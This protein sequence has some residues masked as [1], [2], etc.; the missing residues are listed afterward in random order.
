MHFELRQLRHVVAV[1]EQQSFSKAAEILGLTQPALSRSIAA[2]ERTCGTLIF[3][4]LKGR[5][6]PTGVGLGVIA[7]CE[8]ILAQADRLA[9]DVNRR[10]DAL[11]GSISLGFGPLVAGLILPTLL[12][13]LATE[14]PR[15]KIRTYMDTGDVLMDALAR[16][17][18]EIAIVAK[19]LLPV[20]NDLRVETIG[21]YPLAF[22]VRAG[23]PLVGRQD[24]TMA[25]LEQFPIASGGWPRELRHEPSP[26]PASPQV[27]IACENYAALEEATSSSDIIW[28]SSLLLVRN[29]RRKQFETLSVPGWEN[30]RQQICAA[31]PAEYSLSP[32]GDVVI[33][34]MRQ[35]LLSETTPM[36]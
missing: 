33:D 36:L 17:R 19:G 34:M 26:Q 24:L 32:I 28:L 18:I 15:I 27:S 10:V 2:F 23:H 35:G 12:A 21:S 30:V 13:R 25:D 6:K 8:A 11:I 16:G 4:R 3:D 20:S 7:D 9:C 31:R 1:A 14:R 29:D 22:L 5:I